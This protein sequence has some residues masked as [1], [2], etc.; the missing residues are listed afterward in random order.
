MKCVMRNMMLQKHVFSS[1]I[2]S[3]KAAWQWKLKLNFGLF[4]LQL[5]HSLS[6]NCNR[7]LLRDIDKKLH[8]SAASHLI[9]NLK[10]LTTL[11]N[12]PVSSYVQTYVISCESSCASRDL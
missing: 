1:R 5:L 6:S 11:K 3:L 7:F 12:I 4:P 9:L 8:F 2:K 10:S